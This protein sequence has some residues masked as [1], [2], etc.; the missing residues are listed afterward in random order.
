MCSKYGKV[1]S[2]LFLVVMRTM[3]RATLGLRL[4][5]WAKNG[6]HFQKWGWKQKFCCN[7]GVYFSCRSA[8]FWRTPPEL[9]LLSKN[10]TA[11]KVE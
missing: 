9:L 4:T 7:V 10:L 8:S 11:K 3:Q 6:L 2:P 1:I 5:I